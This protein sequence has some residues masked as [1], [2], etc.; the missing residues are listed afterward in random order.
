MNPPA[1]NAA[2]DTVRTTLRRLDDL[3]PTTRHRLDA[4]ATTLARVADADRRLTES[5]RRRMEELLVAEGGL[6]EAVAVMLVELAR[7]RRT[8][9]GYGAAYAVTRGL[10][11]STPLATRQR[12]LDAVVEVALADG[13]ACGEEREVIRR[14]ACELGLPAPELKRF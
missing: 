8:A 13:H 10:R 5:E 12:L 14:I 4:V 6:E 9:G 1:P 7:Q 2:A 3:E 11:R